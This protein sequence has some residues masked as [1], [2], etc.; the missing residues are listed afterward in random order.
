MRLTKEMREFVISRIVRKS[1][2]GEIQRV[3]DDLQKIGRAAAEHVYGPK[4]RAWMEK[5]P[6][7]ALLHHNQVHLHDWQGNSLQHPA[8]GGRQYRGIAVTLEKPAPRLHK[9]A[10]D[11]TLKLGAGDTKKVSAL[12][13]RADAIEK[14]RKDIRATVSGALYACNTVKQLQDT[15]PELVKYL[16]EAERETKDLTVTRAQ[17]KKVLPKE[18]KADVKR[19]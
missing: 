16:P 12:F 2:D 3:R 19:S 14:A 8:I 15:Y 11:Y 13:K 10:Y 17:L 7:G 9:D 1:T 6:E 5:A 18:E 4:I